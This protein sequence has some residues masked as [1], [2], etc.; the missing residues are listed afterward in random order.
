MIRNR[1]KQSVCAL[2]LLSCGHS[3]AHAGDF[4]FSGFM[5]IGGGFVDDESA[6][7]YAG[8]AEEDITFDNSLLGIQFSSDIANELTATVQLTAR[9]T[10]GFKV[11]AEW[12]YVSWQA[13]DESTVRIGRLRTPFYMYSDYL[14]VGYAYPWIAPPNEVYYLPFNN[15]NGIDLYTTGTLGSFDTTMQ[16]YFGSFTDELNERGV[17]IEAKTRN[18]LGFAGT[19]AKD[20]WTF[21]AAY[22]MAKLSINLEAL[23]DVPELLQTL[24][25]AG[26]SRNADRFRIDEDDAKFIELGLNID[27][28]TFVA[29]AEHVELRFEDETLYADNI[30]Q[31]VMLGVRTGDWLIHLTASKADDEA[32]NLSQ[33]I[34]VTPQTA[35]LIAELNAQAAGEANKRDVISLGTR[36][37]ITAGT[38][39]KF[40]Y[41]DVDRDGQKRQK[42][43]A[44]ALQTV[45]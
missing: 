44:F 17:D 11:E 20:W 38:A 26:F 41:S 40:Q 25:G 45:F 2:A 8:Y 23:P 1:L 42:V 39:L 33:G 43:Y 22:H 31:F 3:L 7:S 4:N 14:D 29:A 35:E 16:V 19:L 13:T 27:T 32:S 37:D 28:G 9:N 18:Q 10:D 30:R 36:W 34:P 12:A 15:V 6:R 5:S 21:R 24:Q